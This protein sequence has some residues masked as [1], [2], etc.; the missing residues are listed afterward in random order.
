[1]C[2]RKSTL[3]VLEEKYF[4]KNNYKYIIVPQQY[5]F[6]TEKDQYRIN[7]LTR[8]LFKGEGFIVYYDLED[9]PEDLREDNCLGLYL[10]LKKIKGGR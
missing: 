4:L 6:S 9:L 3:K 8:V 5:E 10:D 2:L 7:T 1:M